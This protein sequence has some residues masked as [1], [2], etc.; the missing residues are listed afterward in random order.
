MKKTQFKKRLQELNACTEAMKWVGDRTPQQALEQCDRGDW[1]LW[2][3]GKERETKGFPNIREIIL[4]EALCAKLVIHLMKDNRSIQ[5]VEVAE[6]YGRGLATDEE[7][8][9]DAYADADAK[10]K[11][12]LKQCADI[13]REVLY[14]PKNYCKINK[15]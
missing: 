6:R 11:E 12:I 9:T 15:L 7:L 3:I 13:C 4:V 1:L 10:R 14:I 2:W 8:S 5:A